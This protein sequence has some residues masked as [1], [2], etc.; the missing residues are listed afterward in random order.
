MKFLFL[1][2]TFISNLSKTNQIK[3][4]DVAAAEE[5]ARLQLQRLPAFG[6]FK[7]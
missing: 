4:A 6:V 2:G 5:A 7:S 3:A 1:N